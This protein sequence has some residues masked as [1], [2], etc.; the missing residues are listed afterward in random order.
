M[1]EILRRLTKITQPRSQGFTVDVPG[2]YPTLRPF[3]R[4]SLSGGRG[5]GRL[6]GGGT[7]VLDVLG[8][9]C[10]LPLDITKNVI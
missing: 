7:E 2:V 6:G 1:C 9:F 3:D 5:R 4:I 8:L 10:S